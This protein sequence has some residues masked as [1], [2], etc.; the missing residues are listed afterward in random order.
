MAFWTVRGIF[1][2]CLFARTRAY[3]RGGRASRWGTLG[4]NNKR[5]NNIRGMKERKSCACASSP[6][7]PQSITILCCTVFS[8]LTMAR[9]FHPLLWLMTVRL[10]KN[11]F[12][13]IFSNLPSLCNFC[14]TLYTA[15]HDNGLSLSCKV[16]RWNAAVQTS[17]VNLRW[18]C[19]TG[20]HIH[21]HTLQ[22]AQLHIRVFT[23]LSKKIMSSK[24]TCRQQNNIS[25]KKRMWERCNKTI[26]HYIW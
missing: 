3:T 23:M 7:F 8:R 25:N 14:C 2:G 1:R 19:F 18:L 10:K 15:W 16:H 6:R 20:T 26:S 17:Q 5:K 21:T 24:R 4:M 22:G 9:I 12:T 11:I 13:V